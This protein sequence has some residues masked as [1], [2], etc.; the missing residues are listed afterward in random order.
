MRL[1]ANA[2]VPLSQLSTLNSQL[3]S[4]AVSRHPFLDPARA[5]LVEEDLVQ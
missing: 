4:S 1:E 3:V 2:S 5:N